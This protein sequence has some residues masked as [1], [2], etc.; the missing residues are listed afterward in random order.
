VDAEACGAAGG[1]GCSGAR[2]VA[3]FQNL[4][5]LGDVLLE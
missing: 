1:K 4:A 3:I 5:I 2:L